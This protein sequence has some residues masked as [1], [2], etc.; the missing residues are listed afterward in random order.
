[1]SSMSFMG[2][3]A[4]RRAK[5][6]FRLF[7]RDRRWYQGRLAYLCGRLDLQL[8][9]VRRL[10][11]TVLAVLALAAPAA[12]S[13][14]TGSAL[15]PRLASALKVPHV[16]PVRSSA[17]AVDLVTGET[18]YAQNAQ[19]SLAPASNE[20]L[21]LTYALLTAY[22][23]SYRLET[24][25]VRSDNDLYLVGG[26]DP[27][28]DHH[29]LAAL[30]APGTCRGSDVGQARARGRIAGSTPREPRGVGSR[31][32]ISTSRPHFR[33]SSSTA[34]A[35][36]AV[37]PP[38]RRSPRRCSSA[39]PCGAAGVAVTGAV[40]VVPAPAVADPVASV[41]SPTLGSLVEFMDLHSDNFTAE[42]LLKQLGAASGGARD[43]GGRRAD[44]DAAPRRRR[45]S[46]SKECASSTAQGCHSS[47]E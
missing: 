32:S 16:S 14:R 21:P 18:V 39:T 22:G 10:S 33:R 23:P 25:V 29:D 40:A 34:R 45:H 31:R 4:F 11:A 30:G 2:R 20:K 13:T 44:G 19:R 9:R 46:P 24:T 47:T 37:S 36:R 3:G 27:S 5:D 43:D 17:V 35:T 41:R 38:I 28:L 1:M 15:G 26:G 12:A 6:V 8:T 7:P 42:L